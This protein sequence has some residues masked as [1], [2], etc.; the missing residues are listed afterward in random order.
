[1]AQQV[2]RFGQHLVGLPLALAFRKIAFEF[3]IQGLARALDFF[4]RFCAM[5]FVI[6]VCVPQKD[7]GMDYFFTRWLGVNA[8]G[9]RKG[10]TNGQYLQCSQ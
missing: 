5:A 2:T 9:E 7:I 10:D 3:E 4:Q 1:M 8:P 6:V